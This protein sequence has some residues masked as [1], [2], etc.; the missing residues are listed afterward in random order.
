MS[1]ALEEHDRKVSIGGLNI[2]N[3]GF[4]G[5]IDALAE[6]EQKLE[7]LVESLNKTCSRYKMEI[8]TEQTKLMTK[9][10]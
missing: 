9:S 6:K 2:I 7:P 8:S 1:D 5:D 3:L 4:A 10:T